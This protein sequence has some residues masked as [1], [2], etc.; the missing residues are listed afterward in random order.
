MYKNSQEPKNCFIIMVDKH[1][2][3][4]FEPAQT[5]CA[6]KKSFTYL[7]TASNSQNTKTQCNNDPSRINLRKRFY[8]NGHKIQDWTGSIIPG[9]AKWQEIDATTGVCLL[10]L[11]EQNM[12][13]GGWLPVDV[14][15]E[16]ETKVLLVHYVTH[17]V[18]HRRRWENGGLGSWS[19]L[20]GSEAEKTKQNKKK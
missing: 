3:W 12:R 5:I 20:S 15:A 19:C 8:E 6:F 16:K 13:V 11:E 2:G 9:F 1:C 17:Y 10:E 4:S 14:W 7:R 18:T